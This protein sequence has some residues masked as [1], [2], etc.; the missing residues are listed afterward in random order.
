MWPPPD[1]LWLSTCR[2][3]G[4]LLVHVLGPVIL[5]GLGLG[6]SFVP[7]TLSATAGVPVHEAGLAS[8]LINTTRQVG[9]ALG[10]AIMATIAAGAAR[11]A[12]RRGAGARAVASGLT[13][14]YDRAFWISAFTLMV[15]SALALV[16][17]PAQR[18]ATTGGPAPS[19][20]ERDHLDLQADVGAAMTSTEG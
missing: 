15:G 12:T 9:G 2:G 11:A 1:S 3:R 17:L 20:P 13:T 14:G 10:L 8:G 6:L 7:M 18:R 4:R 19:A 5:I 16:L